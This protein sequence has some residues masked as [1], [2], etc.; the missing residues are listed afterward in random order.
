M[1]YCTRNEIPAKVLFYDIVTTFGNTLQYVKRQKVAMCV[2]FAVAH[3][4]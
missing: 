1:N 3:T 2:H 4:A